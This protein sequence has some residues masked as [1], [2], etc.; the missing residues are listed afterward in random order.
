MPSLYQENII[1]HTNVSMQY[2]MSRFNTFECA[3]SPKKKELP[4]RFDKLHDDYSHFYHSHT[5]VSS[6]TIIYIEL[7]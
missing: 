6:P 2:I 5:T 4:V 7:K 3:N 1:L